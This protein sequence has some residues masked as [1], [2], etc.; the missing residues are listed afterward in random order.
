MNRFFFVFVF[1]CFF[2][3]RDPLGAREKAAVP[4]IK[5]N[6]AKNTKMKRAIVKIPNWENR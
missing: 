1:F 6:W 5:F 3:F 4:Q 2:L